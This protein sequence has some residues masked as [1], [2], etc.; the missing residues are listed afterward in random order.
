MEKL[1]HRKR[2]GEVRRT[3]WIRNVENGKREISRALGHEIMQARCPGVKSCC[4]SSALVAAVDRT[5]DQAGVSYSMKSDV[6]NE[7]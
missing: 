3:S 4:L 6:G 2:R 5:D 1:T 7:Q